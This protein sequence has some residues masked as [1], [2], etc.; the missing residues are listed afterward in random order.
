MLWGCSGLLLCPSHSEH[1]CIPQCHFPSGEHHLYPLFQPWD[2]FLLLLSIASSDLPLPP[3]PPPLKLAA[4]IPAPS[5]CFLF[6][7]SSSSCPPGPGS[8][9]SL[10]ELPELRAEAMFTFVAVRWGKVT[11]GELNATGKVHTSPF[12]PCTV[13]VFNFLPAESC[14]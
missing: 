8:V 6:S 7:S 9:T 13:N 14:F 4:G 2:F 11:V 10:L 12:V 5:P 1:G 3:A